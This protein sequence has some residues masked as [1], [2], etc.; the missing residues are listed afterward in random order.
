MY[1]VRIEGGVGKKYLKFADK[2]HLN[3]ADKEGRGSKT[4]TF[5]WT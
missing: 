3:F 1:D 2:Q 4:K 5:L